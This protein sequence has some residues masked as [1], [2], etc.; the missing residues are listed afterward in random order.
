MR[1]SPGTALELY[2]ENVCPIVASS[3]HDT[4]LTDQKSSSHC[5][6]L[7]VPRQRYSN[8]HFFTLLSSQIYTF[9]SY[10]FIV[11]LRLVSISCLR[12]I[13]YIHSDAIL[14]INV[15]GASEAC[16]RIIPRNSEVFPIAL[17]KEE[18]DGQDW[19]LN[20]CS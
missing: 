12:P 18:L 7:A 11:S 2:V 4:P 19:V 10:P 5:L 1:H 20:T 14:I 3:R 15:I 9:I 8:F 16:G 17:L 13:C 6:L